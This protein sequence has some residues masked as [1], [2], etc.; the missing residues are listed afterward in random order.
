MQRLKQKVVYEL[1]HL[2]RQL[3]PE[4]TLE[5]QLAKPFKLCRT[6]LSHLLDSRILL[7]AEFTEC[8]ELNC[9]MGVLRVPFVVVCLTRC[10]MG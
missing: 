2:A 8:I 4:V 3:V 1:K 7:R 10:F 6:D 5:V 9:L